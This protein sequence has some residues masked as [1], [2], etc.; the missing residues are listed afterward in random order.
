MRLY[1]RILL[2]FMKYVF[3]VVSGQPAWGNFMRSWT[4]LLQPV[5]GCA[6]YQTEST[7][8]LAPSF[9]QT[10]RM[11]VRI[12]CF[13]DWRVRWA[14][15]RSSCTNPPFPIDSSIAPIRRILA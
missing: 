4:C 11:K 3:P 14:W 12:Y 6:G 2:T 5:F 10:C 9:S 1:G 7:T 8:E 15:K 13:I